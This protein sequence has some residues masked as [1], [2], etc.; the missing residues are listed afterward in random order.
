MT[1]TASPEIVYDCQNINC[2]LVAQVPDE[3]A[4]VTIIGRREPHQLVMMTRYYRQT[5]GV[6]L[7]T[8]LEKRASDSV[9]GLLARA[10]QHKIIADA[11]YIHNAGKTNRKHEQFRRKDNTMQVLLEVLTGRKPDEI[12]ELQEAFQALFRTELESYVVKLLKDEEEAVHQFF[13]E[14]LKEKVNEPLPDMAAAVNQL[15]GLLTT[16]TKERYEY[17]LL[18][19][20]SKLTTSQLDKLVYAYNSEHRG[21]HVVTVLRNNFK[22]KK[23]NKKVAEMVLFTVMR[24]ADAPRHIAHQFE[25]SMSGMGT[26]EDQLSRLVARHCG[27][28]M[29]KVLDA[30]KVDFDRTLADRIRGDTSGLYC[31][32]LLHLIQQTV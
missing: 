17:N 21:A 19:Y 32:L 29:Q 25:E 20:V 16:E 4:L 3:D 18:E 26:H 6:D 14:L 2:A 12:K 10:C 1:E 23:S 8:E 27:K 22:S 13:I 7:P 24:C 28:S 15:H 5:Y 31:N 9:G 11:H 30:Y